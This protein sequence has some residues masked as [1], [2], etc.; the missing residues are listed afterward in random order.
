M[1]KGVASESE[2][3]MARAASRISSQLPGC[4]SSGSP[5]SA[6]TSRW[7]QRA[8]VSVVIGTP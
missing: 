3:L 7:N 2:S 8:R 1:K 4:Q 6:N 5:A